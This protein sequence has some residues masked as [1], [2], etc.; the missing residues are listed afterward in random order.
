MKDTT[1]DM[2]KIQRE[3]FEK[4]SIT[5]RLKIG[6]ELIDFGRKIIEE[7]IKTNDPEIS[8]ANLNIQ[9]FRERYSNIL[10]PE[11]IESVALSMGNYFSKR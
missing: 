5:E 7:R 9:V 8:V 11:I 2:I 10:S 6:C 1:E 3:I 4:K